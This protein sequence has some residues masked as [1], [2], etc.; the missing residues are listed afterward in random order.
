MH[1]GGF[2]Y[3]TFLLF[4]LLSSGKEGWWEERGESSIGN[5]VLSA[6]LLPPGPPWPAPLQ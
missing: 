6:Q 2:E 4:I 3:F 5:K 1:T